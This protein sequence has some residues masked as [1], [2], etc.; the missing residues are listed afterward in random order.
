MAIDAARGMLYLH[1][2]T[3]NKPIIVHRDL[4]SLNLLVDKDWNCKVADFG[5]SKASSGQSLN[6]KLGSLNWCAPEILLAHG[7]PY[8][9]AADTY[10]FGMVL[11]ELI[12]HIPPYNGQSPLNIVRAKDVN[13]TPTFPKGVDPE[14]KKFIK[15]CWHRK[16]QSR[17]TFEQIIAKLE[18]F[19]KSGRELSL[20]TTE[21]QKSGSGSAVLRTTVT[22]LAKTGKGVGIFGSKGAL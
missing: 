11:W 8:T 9:T 4:K 14:L 17:P 18:G 21:L 13:E 3:P 16:P 22:P 10:S 2:S 20:P 12:S 6:S 5:L 19:L 1:T 15:E 7:T